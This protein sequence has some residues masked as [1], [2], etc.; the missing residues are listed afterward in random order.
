MS[1]VD[2]AREQAI[3]LYWR[4]QANRNAIARPIP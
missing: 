1:V 2:T 3:P 4:V